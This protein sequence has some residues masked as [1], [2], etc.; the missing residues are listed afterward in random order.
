MECPK[1]GN[2][3]ANYSRQCGFCSA[4]IPPGQYLLEE[5]G[6]VERSSPTTATTTMPAWGSQLAVPRTATLGDRLIAA[7]LD[8]MVALAA[9]S[10]IGVWSFR[11]W[12]ISTGGDF[13]LTSASLLAAGILSAIFLY[14]YLWLLE[15]CFGATLG[16]AIVGI[17]VV[18]ITPRGSLSASA[19]RN[20]LRIVDAIGFYVVG[21]IFAGCSKL[22]QR[23]GDVLAGTIVVEESYAPST[24]LFALLLWVAALTGTGWGLPKIYSA[25]FSNQRPTYFAD[26]VV[27]L[28]YT[29]DSAYVCVSGLRIDLRRDSAARLDDVVNGN[30]SLVDT[31]ANLPQHTRN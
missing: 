11:K 12:G 8:G 27:Q 26:T 10:V 9:F 29:A 20:A 13:Y 19:I 23:L 22:R 4:K 24:K 1:C 2:D 15:G 7:A 17:S 31:S 16:K 6:V 18:R 14:L 21:A 25:G 28:G 30:P 3:I 5:S